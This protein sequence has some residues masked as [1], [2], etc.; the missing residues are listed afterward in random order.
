MVQQ[1]LYSLRCDTTCMKPAGLPVKLVD[2]TGTRFDHYASLYLGNVSDDRKKTLSEYADAVITRKTYFD[3]LHRK[4]WLTQE[5]TGH[6]DGLYWRTKVIFNALV[7]EYVEKETKYAEPTL[8]PMHHTYNVLRLDFLLGLREYALAHYLGMTKASLHK[9]LVGVRSK[10]SPK[11]LSHA[12]RLGQDIARAEG[13]PVA[14]NE[15]AK[16]LRARGHHRGREFR[17][18]LRRRAARAH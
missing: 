5:E 7:D 8:V 13:L 15:A 2:Y 4:G 14:Q 18:R 6:A 1:L 16:F 11:P 17:T 10:T 9:M 12:Q 3:F